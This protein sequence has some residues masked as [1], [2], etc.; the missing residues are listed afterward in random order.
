MLLSYPFRYRRLSPPTFFHA[1]ILTLPLPPT[2]T[3]YLFPCY[4]PNP[5]PTADRNLLPFSM[6]LS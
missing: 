1:T 5:T 2:V 3:F 6:L 4:Y